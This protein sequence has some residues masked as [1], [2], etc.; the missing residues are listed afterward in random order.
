[1]FRVEK[2][3]WVPVF[4]AIAMKLPEFR[5]K[6][7]E[8][9]AILHKS[10]V[11][12]GKDESV[13]GVKVD[14]KEIDPF[15]FIALSIKGGEKLRQGHLKVVLKQLG[16]NL[17]VPTDF[18]G[19]P[20]VQSQV[21]W[22]FS[23]KRDRGAKDI[24]LLWDLFTEA[25]SGNVGAKTFDRALS[26]RQ[27]GF[28][29]LTQ[30]LFYFFPDSFLPVDSVTR[31]YLE[32][33]G[34]SAPQE[35]W[36]S[37][38]SF[39]EDVKK[40]IGAEFHEISFEAWDSVQ[41]SQSDAIRYLSNRY[42]VSGETIH[43]VT[44]E[45]GA[46]KQLA[47]DPELK[48]VVKV[49][50]ESDISNKFP[51][52]VK[53]YEKNKSRNHHLKKNAP[54]L[55]QGKEAFLVSLSSEA[56]LE[57]LCNWYDKRGS[58]QKNEANEKKGMEENMQKIEL[59]SIL[60]GPPGT[61]KTY[62]TVRHALEILGEKDSSI[63]DIRGIKRLKDEFPGQVEFV[64]FHQS[65]SY[66][67]F[68][69]GLKA[70]I[71]GGQISYDVKPGVFKEICN[72]ASSKGM[73]NSS[74]ERIDS[75]AVI[76]KMSLG[77][78]K[79][80]DATIYFEEAQESNSLVLGWG[81]MTD[82][83]KC[84][85]KS[86]IYSLCK[87]GG[88]R[89]VTDFIFGMKEGDIVIISDGN[90]KF[91]A[92]AKVTGPYYYDESSDLPQ[93]RGIEWLQIFSESR[94]ALEISEKNF[95]QSTINKPQHINKNRLEE[96]LVD[97]SVIS[98]DKPYILIIDEINRGNIS[99]IFGELITLIEPTKREGTKEAISV[100]LPYSKKPFS[101]PN[102]L[103]IIGTMNTADRS[104]ALVDTALRRR[105]DFI[106]MLPDYDLLLDALDGVNLQ[107]MLKVMNQRIEA[108]Y[109]REHMIGHSFLMHLKDI[110]DLNHAFNNK[111][112]PLLE[113]YFHDDWQKI[114]L[115][116]A[117][118]SDLFYEKVSYES[119]LF[120]GMENETEQKESYRRASSSDI[121]K[122]A[123]IRIYKSSSEVDEGSS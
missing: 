88:A 63:K 52:K 105:F 4:R 122:D 102:N 89:F 22:L 19:V 110:K 57:E 109:D 71:V 17:A 82:F 96:C 104:L 74:T 48:T 24:S 80:E 58:N 87:K 8:L 6:Q 72:R 55:A 84:K 30:Y 121:K 23:Y 115:V 123:F 25:L 3:T 103:Y 51:Y 99:R 50:I 118:S 68:V 43:I 33:L 54:N 112:L 1:M 94:P 101:V 90:Y 46:G 61:G 42:G 91:K 15:T 86:D 108:L 29:K 35:N 95:T 65:F 27:V 111:I 37:Y 56:E 12:V 2:Y 75:D 11:K 44:F 62:S 45:N 26:V 100:Q 39:L 93:K 106:E 9:I 97:E 5:N 7:K 60:Y 31:P 120:K 79:T 36:I 67:D 40:N 10:G 77:Y 70:D 53:Y 113:E 20:S 59:N 78:S 81:G 49:L 116:L 32:G 18:C 16:V 107:K 85:D 21:A 28:T 114:K 117:D 76:W 14:L 73:C 13:D 34:V 64:T 98:N 47:L 66:E 119:D 83:T 92:I 38:I 69:E 41:Y